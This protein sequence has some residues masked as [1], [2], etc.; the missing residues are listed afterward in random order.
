MSKS[1]SHYKAL[2][3][4]LI[5]ILLYWLGN[6]IYV[7][8]LSDSVYE[9]IRLSP[10]LETNHLSF[11]AIG[12]GPIIMGF[13]FSE[14]MSFVIPPVS[15]WRKLGRAGRNKINVLALALSVLFTLAAIYQRVQF[16]AIVPAPGQGEMFAPEVITPLLYTFFFLGAVSLFFLGRFMT[17]YGL[18]N[19]FGVLVIFDIIKYTGSTIIKDIKFFMTDNSIFY[20]PGIFFFFLFV[21]VLY[22]FVFKPNKTIEI[23]FNNKIILYEIPPVPQGLFA[24]IWSYNIIL[25]PSAFWPDTAWARFASQDWSYSIFFALAFLCISFFTFWLAFSFKR[26]KNNVSVSINPI[27]EKKYFSTSMKSLL[28]VVVVSFLLSM[29]RPFEQEGFLAL[30]W[31]S[32]A[33]LLLFYFIGKDIFDHFRFLQRHVEVVEIEEFDNIYYAGVAKGYLLSMQ[34]DCHLQGFELRR[35]YAFISP[36]YK[37]K[38]LVPKS[39]LA[40]V[41]NLLK[42]DTIE[43]I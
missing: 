5:G 21:W 20:F 13:F 2:M 4:S 29:P 41:K 6:H 19:G 34:I 22:Y 17:T 27:S 12:L 30:Q 37:T 14:V 15:K 8:Y 39:K 33:Y 9:F 16:L 38:L 28:I 35:L 25:L 7:P 1:Q 36:I 18:A 10:A 11:F 31:I 42:T 26:I 43:I 3:I 32:L 24:I 40:E 23:T